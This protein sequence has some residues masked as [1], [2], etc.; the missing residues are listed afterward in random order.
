MRAV[1]R[2]AVGVDWND[3]AGVRKLET[4]NSFA[5]NGVCLGCIQRFMAS[6]PCFR[7][8]MERKICGHPLTQ[9]LQALVHLRVVIYLFTKEGQTF[10]LRFSVRKR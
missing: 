8:I 10:R 7:V 2:G 6:E 4:P 1:R 5:K 9:H 3:A